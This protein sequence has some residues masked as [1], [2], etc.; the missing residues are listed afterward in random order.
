MYSPH[1]LTPHNMQDVQ[2]DALR[3]WVTSRP[4]TISPSASIYIFMTLSKATPMYSGPP[5]PCM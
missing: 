5:Y 3:T 4:L 1:M 2:E